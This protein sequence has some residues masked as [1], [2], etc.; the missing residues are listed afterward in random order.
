LHIISGGAGLRSTIAI[1]NALAQ[2][3]KLITG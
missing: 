2:I 3:N 1:S